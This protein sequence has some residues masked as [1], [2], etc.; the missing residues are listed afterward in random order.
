MK[1]I[2][3]SI[4]TVAMAM[5]YSVAQIANPSFENWGPDTSYLDLTTIGGPK[6]TAYFQDPL[7]WTSV[8][9]V[10]GGKAFGVK[11]FVS[12][13][14]QA[15]LGA[16]ALRCVTDTVTV[17]VLLSQLTLPG[18]VIS[19]DFK[20]SLTSFVGGNFSPTNIPGAGIAINP[21]R[22]IG[23]FEGYYQYAPVAGKV[24]QDS[25]A[26]IAVLK[27]GSQVIAQANF[28][29]VNPQS[30]YAKFSVDFVYNSC[31]I[32]DSAV[33][34]L[35]S[36]NPYS[37]Q[38]LLGGGTAT[39]PIGGAA[40]FDDI[41]LVDTTVTFSIPPIAIADTASTKK[42]TPKNISVLANDLSCY[43]GTLS[44]ALPSSTS[45][46]G[47][48]AV[49][50]TMV[51]YTPTTGYFGPD[52][53]YY[54]LSATGSP[55]TATGVVAVNVINNVG[56][57]TIDAIAASVYPNPVQTRLTIDADAKIVSKVVVT[58]VVGKVIATENIT[59]DKTFINTSD[60][61]NGLYVV[62]LMDASGRI[63][64]TS[65]ITVEK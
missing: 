23:K 52:T 59:S 3:L 9:A 46:H 44:V 36:S 28:F 21:P 62:S 24:G 57:N 64:Y 38:S 1:K 34:I 32:P 5:S 19:G 50:G 42:N 10:I 45:P 31:L 48:L 41:A 13:T 49:T 25:C 53:F 20:I 26:A 7:G 30:T 61:Q 65:R 2:L 17:P 16:N 63:R 40:L 37:L 35:A 27:K 22:R 58:D 18:F 12:P 55:V 8:N 14:T 15:N 47:A 4:V 54:T 6:D 39:L 29:A 11:Q 33:I 43:G 51:T 56:I 60:F